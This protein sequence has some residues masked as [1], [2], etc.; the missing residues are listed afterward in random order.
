MQRDVLQKVLQTATGLVE[1][2]TTYS[3]PSEHRVTVYLGREGRGVV[4]S[5]VEEVRL[6]DAFVQIIARDA[7]EVYAEYAEISALSVK[8]P[9]GDMKARAGFA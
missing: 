3:A 8:P 1:K 9:K 6:H 5:E 7:G 2:G 4:V